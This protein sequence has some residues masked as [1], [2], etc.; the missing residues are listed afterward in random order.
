MVIVGLPRKNLALLSRSMIF[1]GVIQ[2]TILTNIGYG[3]TVA[4]AQIWEYLVKMFILSMSI[5]NGDIILMDWCI[6]SH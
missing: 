6:R 5:T 2:M 3:Y 1:C 4:A